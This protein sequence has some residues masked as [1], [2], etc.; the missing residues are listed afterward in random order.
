MAPRRRLT[1][2]LTVVAVA[3]VA[4]VILLIP[5]QEGPPAP[6]AV[7]GGGMPPTLE[8]GVLM[9]GTAPAPPFVSVAPGSV[10]GF[11][12]DLVTEVARRLGLRLRFVEAD[13]ADP[14]AAL[15][16]GELDV[17]VSA[18]RTTPELEERVN[19]TDPYYRV[20]QAVVVNHD[21]RPDLAGVAGLGEG[22]QVGVVEGS[23]AQAWVLAHLA[24]SA[25]GVRTFA[26]ADQAAIG[27]EAGAVDAV[28]LD[29]TSAG[30]EAAPRMSLQIVETI[31]TGEGLAI[32]V[33]PG[34]PVLL[35]AVNDVLSE[36]V[37]DGT[38]DRLYDRYGE[39]LPAGG[40]ITAP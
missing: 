9:A 19:L 20:R 18:A 39:S 7:S 23:T 36:L 12:V 40:R 21:V 38:Y 10:S 35:D 37:D 27:L 32:A 5:R 28:I 14:Y 13:P 4:G 31:V 6:V 17:V 8:N 30:T 29:E 26:D 15:A 3:V 33:D 22:D 1:P 16:L 2:F 25:I 34:N 11:A 24:P